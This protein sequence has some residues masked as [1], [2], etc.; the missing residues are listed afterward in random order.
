MSGICTGLAS[1]IE[2]LRDA[3]KSTLA[4][5]PLRTLSSSADTS[6]T[7]PQRR[8]VPLLLDYEPGQLVIFRA[9]KHSA[10]PGPRAED[11]HPEEGGEKYRYVVDKFWQ[12]I[13]VD[14]EHREVVLAT[15]RGKKRRLPVDHPA[16]RKPNFWERWRY[17]KQWDWST[18]TTD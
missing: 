16:L 9:T 17:R 13:G 2:G 14:P 15:R 7:C 11:I 1:K 10:R 5:P 6:A 18:P 3:P 12:V 8:S 4:L